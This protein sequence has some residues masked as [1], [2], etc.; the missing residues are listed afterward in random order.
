[1]TH[2]PEILLFAVGVT[3]E[4]QSELWTPAWH[5]P[6]PGGTPISELPETFEPNG[7]EYTGP[8]LNTPE[9]DAILIVA[10]LK[11]LR[12]SNVEVRF[13]AY[14]KLGPFWFVTHN[15]GHA[16]AKAIAEV[17]NG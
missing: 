10:G 5:S 7:F 1:M 8:A 14:E 16:L 2:N 4:T 11:C 15:P 9:L 17:R 13:S 3:N 6:R 12:E